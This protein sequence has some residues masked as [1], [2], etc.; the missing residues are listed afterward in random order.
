M[1]L[2]NNNTEA[3][4]LTFQETAKQNALKTLRHA[5]F[6]RNGKTR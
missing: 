5:I 6:I 4:V 3:K 1:F 2:I